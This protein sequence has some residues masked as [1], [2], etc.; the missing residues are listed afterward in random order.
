MK[1]AHSISHELVHEMVLLANAEMF[2]CEFG[3]E[4]KAE[5][6]PKMAESMQILPE[7]L[8]SESKE[9]CLLEAAERVYQSGLTYGYTLTINDM[10]GILSRSYMLSVIYKK[11]NGEM[12]HKAVL[13]LYSDLADAVFHHVHIFNEDIDLDYFN[14]KVPEFFEHQITLAEFYLLFYYYSFAANL[15]EWQED[16]HLDS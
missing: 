14:Q 15:M 1:T 8:F 9:P 13:N 5:E 10:K 16:I 2:K 12:D 3:F 4:L 6:I 7:A 11:V